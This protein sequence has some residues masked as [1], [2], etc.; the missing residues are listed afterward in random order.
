MNKNALRMGMTFI[1]LTILG[2]VGGF[3]LVVIIDTVP[4][5]WTVIK[6][7]W[8]AVSIPALLLGSGSVTT[9]LII[10]EIIESKYNAVREVMEGMHPWARSLIKFICL[11]AITTAIIVIVAFVWAL[12]E[13]APD[14]WTTIKEVL[15]PATTGQIITTAIIA[16]VLITLIISLCIVQY[17]LHKLETVVTKAKLNAENKK[18]PLQ[19]DRQLLALKLEKLKE[20]S[21]VD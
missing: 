17:E 13:T 14:L 21:H 15:S 4:F 16:V 2:A 8:E 9:A 1:I 19:S 5:L 11:A 7:T 20:D 6:N 3:L 12:I 18:A 10:L